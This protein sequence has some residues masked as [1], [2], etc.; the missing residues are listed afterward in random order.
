MPRV[1]LALAPDTH[2]RLTQ[3]QR[4]FASPPP[5]SLLASDVPTLREPASPDRAWFHVWVGLGTKCPRG[6]TTPYDPPAPVPTSRLRPGRSRVD[7]DRI[8]HPHLIP[9]PPPYTQLSLEASVVWLVV[10]LSQ[11]PHRFAIH[12]DGFS[13]H[14]QYMVTY[15]G[16]GSVL[17][18]TRGSASRPWHL[19][20]NFDRPA[21]TAAT[22]L[23]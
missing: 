8:A 2:S 9:F 21:S 14:V 11:P 15:A 6:D 1:R 7:P 17:W 10:F 4:P 3:D 22:A 13:T 5:R 19:T 23:R 18:I 16:P 12:H 20:E